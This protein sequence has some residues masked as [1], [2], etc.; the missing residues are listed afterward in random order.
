[1]TEQPYNPLDKYNLADSISLKITQKTLIPL[2]D[3]HDIL[4]SGIYLL[5]YTGDVSAYRE[6]SRPIED[7]ETPIY[8]GRAIPAGGRKGGKSETVKKDKAISARLQQHA[9]SIREAH[10]LKLEDFYFRHLVIDPIWIPLAENALIGRYR[11]VWNLAVDGFGNKDPGG[12]R[13]TQH[14]SPWDKLHPG[15]LFA[16]K[17]AESGASTDSMRERV[18]DHFAGRKLKPLPKKAKEAMEEAKVMDV[19]EGGTL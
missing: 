16:E 6:I 3:A 1:M 5:Y 8:V 18:A 2:A 11:P 10:D 4:G 9:G 12:R 15:R 14:K 19:L 7:L 17:L 13:A